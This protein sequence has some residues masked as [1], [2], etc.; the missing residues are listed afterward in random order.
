MVDLDQ[1]DYN[2]EGGD[3]MS[4]SYSS[5]WYEWWCY[6]SGLSR[7]SGMALTLQ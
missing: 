3:A 5:I 1:D 6:H 7:N 4:E 2:K